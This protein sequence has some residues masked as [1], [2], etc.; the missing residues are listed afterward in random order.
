MW[1]QIRNWFAGSPMPD[2]NHEVKP[3]VE[4]TRLADLHIAPGD[5][6][7]F[8]AESCRQL[9]DS[10]VKEGAETVGDV[11]RLGIR[12]S[13]EQFFTGNRCKHS[14]A[15]NVC[16]DPPY[17]TAESWF[18]H[19]KAVRSHE[20]VQ[21]ILVQI[22][23]VEP[24]E[25]G[26]VGI[27]PYADTIWVYSDLDQSTIASLLAAIDPDEIRDASANDPNWD[28]KPPSDVPAGSTPYWVWWD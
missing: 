23:M 20:Q 24:Y 1:Q 11:L 17:D 3:P 26:H 25:D 21:D 28:L 14:I 7:D 10:L 12:V 13:L 15:A 8:D 9:L 16:P 19:L 5:G 18:K 27:W 6:E 22:S 2:A 4:D